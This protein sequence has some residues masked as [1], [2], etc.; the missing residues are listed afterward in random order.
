MPSL[1]FLNKPFL[2]GLSAVVV[3][4]LIHLFAR[5]KARKL[6]FSTVDF[7]KEVSRRQKK[8]LQIR[9]LLLMV[10]RMAALASFAIAMARPAVIGSFARNKGSAA[11]VVILDNS[12]SMGWLRGETNRFGAASEIARQVFAGLKD[13]DEGGLIPACGG[14]PG[15]GGAQGSAA[16]EAGLERGLLVAGPARL[17][18]MVGLVRLSN[19]SCAPAQALSQAYSLLANSRNL[20]KELYVISDFQSARWQN[21]A[22]PI[23]KGGRD[24][25]TILVPVA[26]SSSHPLGEN[27]SVENASVVPL[28]S[29]QEQVIEFEVANHGRTEARGVPVRLKAAGKEVGLKYTEVGPNSATKVSF[30]VPGEVGASR[31]T[32]YEIVLPADAFPLDNSYFTAIEPAR[33]SEVLIVGSEERPASSPDFVS[34]ALRP[35]A[36]GAA[37]NIWGFIP[38]RIASD[39]LNK[40][41]LEKTQCVVL[42]NVGRLSS[43]GLDLLREYKDSGGKL[44]IVLG[45]RIDVRYYNEELLPALFPARLIGVEGTPELRSPKARG[46][47]SSAQSGEPGAEARGQESF[48][49]LIADIPSHP[50]LRSFNVSR[51]QAVSDAR[52]YRLIRAEA[53]QD[54]RLVAE[55]SP[56]LPAILES[57]G[58][59]LFTSSFDPSW[60]DLVVSSSFVPLLHEMLRYLCGGGPLAGRNFYPGATLEEEIP[61]GQET[62]FSL[63]APSGAELRTSRTLAGSSLIIKS[64]PMNE[65]G[66]YRLFAGDKEAS[67]FSV[68]VNPAD[69]QSD[70]LD[71]KALLK[72]FPGAEIVSADLVDKGARAG[73]F[74]RARPGLELWP[75]FLL[76]CLCFL[77]AETLVARSIA[78]PE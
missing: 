20:S 71:K 30:R 35:A 60:N 57:S 36:L 40:A 47:L 32:E 78:A 2:I 65:L 75:F 16:A 67:A 59:L 61:S 21:P 44:L 62:S 34:L 7:I 18:G 58:A 50:I 11:A 37:G 27:L 3:P 13:K 73:L 41:E 25:R 12:A 42:D 52:F 43:H 8:R 56:G 63:V 31:S 26:Q 53:L 19:G 51:G 9:N 66:V 76:L 49:S 10:L 23:P 15:F 72:V 39:L 68:N 45:D 77:V 28:T 69:S 22:E 64:E 14:G 54:T 17:S 55:F 6:D 38:H 46:E 70:A 48:F 5:K 4:L 74:G 33:Q 29:T 24:I 1:L